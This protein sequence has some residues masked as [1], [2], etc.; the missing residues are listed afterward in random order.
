MREEE[1]IKNSDFRLTNLLQRIKTTIKIIRIAVPR[2][3]ATMIIIIVV[4]VDS[5]NSKTPREKINE[6]IPLE[7]HT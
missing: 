1:E 2:T 6:R 7:C 5:E 4:L 3:A